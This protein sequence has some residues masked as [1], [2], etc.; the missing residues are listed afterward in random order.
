MGFFYKQTLQSRFA[1]IVFDGVLG[2]PH[3]ACHTYW[4]P[5][6]SEDLGATQE[7]RLRALEGRYVSSKSPLRVRDGD[8]GVAERNYRE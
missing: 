5:S 4:C 1:G 6:I 3:L 7:A 2:P 8:E